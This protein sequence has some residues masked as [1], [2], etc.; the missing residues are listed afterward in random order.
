M[1]YVVDLVPSRLKVIQNPFC[2]EI[3]ADLPSM[4]RYSVNVHKIECGF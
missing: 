4:P 2:S 1:R 3:S